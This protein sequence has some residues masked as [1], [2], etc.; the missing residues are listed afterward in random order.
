M[1]GIP[2]LASARGGIP[3]NMNGGGFLFA[4]P[5]RCISNYLA[6]P[7]PEE[8]RPWLEQIRVLIED[9]KAYDEASRRAVEAAGTFHTEAIMASALRMLSAILG[10]EIRK[11]VSSPGHE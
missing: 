2:V 6:V 7:T 4:P 1:N 10:E 3:E 11:A 8:V 5:E 9:E